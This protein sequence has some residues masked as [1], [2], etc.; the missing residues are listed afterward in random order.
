MGPTHSH[1]AVRALVRPV[2]VAVHVHLT[3]AVWT[4]VAARNHATIRIRGVLRSFQPTDEINSRGR[5]LHSPFSP[6]WPPRACNRECASTGALDP[7]PTRPTLTMTLRL[8]PS[9]TQ[10]AH[11]A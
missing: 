8:D 2:A 4:P 11:A 9:H 3:S 6:F 5:E 7:P 10:R 1:A